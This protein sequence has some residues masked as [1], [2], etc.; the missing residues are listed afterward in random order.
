MSSKIVIIILTPKIYCNL[1]RARSD[2]EKSQIFKSY[3]LEKFKKI[4]NIAEFVHF[5]IF[6]HF[7]NFFSILVH[8]IMHHFFFIKFHKNWGF[9]ENNFEKVNVFRTLRKRMLSMVFFYLYFCCLIALFTDNFLLKNF[10]LFLLQN[11][12]THVTCVEY[13]VCFQMLITFF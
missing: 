9:L 13:T 6:T 5:S 2:F 4:L 1:K 11:I 3:F 12:L 10:A 7:E 8:W